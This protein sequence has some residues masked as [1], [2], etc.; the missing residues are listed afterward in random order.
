MPPPSYN[1]YK[2]L[3][4][5]LQQSFV[6]PI[7]KGIISLFNSSAT[8]EA[9]VDRKIEYI[10]DWDSTKGWESDNEENRYF[11]IDFKDNVVFIP[12][13]GMRPY[14]SDHVPLEWKIYGSNDNQEWIEIDHKTGNLCEGYME[15]REDRFPDAKFCM[16]YLEKF[17]DT[18]NPGYYHMIKVQQIGPNSGSLYESTKYAQSSFYLGAFEIYGEIMIPMTFMITPKCAFWRMK[19]TYL[20]FTLTMKP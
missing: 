14:Y 6:N 20:L 18:D 13:Y 19:L 10:L 9:G 8:I 1:G 12:S 15:F 16:K 11:I 3:L 17:F 2:P 4:Y 5:S 7:Q